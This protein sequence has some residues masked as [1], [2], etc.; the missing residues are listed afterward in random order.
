MAYICSNS[1][2]NSKCRRVYDSPTSD[3]FCID[4]GYD[5][6]LIDSSMD[7][8][9][10]EEYKGTQRQ[11]GLCVLL[12]DASGSMDTPAFQGNPNTKLKLISI[13]AARAIFELKSMS[14]PEDAYICA[15][16][17]DDKVEQMFFKT[18]KEII[19]EFGDENTFADYLYSELLKMQ[20]TTDI[21]GALKAAFSFVDKF[22]KKQIPNFQDYT[23]LEHDGYTYN[24]TI[25]KLPNAR[26]LIYS[27]G[28]QYVNG[29]T[30]PLTNPFREMDVDILMGAFFGK[31]TDAGCSELRSIMSKCPKHGNEQFF[32]IDNPSKIAGLRNLFKMASGASGFCPLCIPKESLK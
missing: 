4:C 10:S 20:G 25:K 28:Q 12:M 30:E 22:L 27:D 29:V 13:N 26:V 16:K 9:I 32:L 17:F 6:L 23:P 31:D 7:E 14:M 24:G 15:M 8:N 11:I 2:N 5:G 19:N 1:D 18:I 21:N 3:Y